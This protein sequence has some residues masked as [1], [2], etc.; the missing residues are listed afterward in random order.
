MSARDYIART[1]FCIVLLV[2][3]VVGANYSV[4]PYGI[5]GAARVDGF[6]RF[7]VDIND[8]ARLLKR[9]QPMNAEYNA[10]I[11]GNSR[12]EMGLDPSHSCLVDAG[13]NTYNLGVPG[14]SVRMQMN[15]ALNVTYQQPIQA[16]FLSLDFPDFIT[17]DPQPVASLTSLMEE[18]SGS[19][20]LLPSGLPNP[21]YRSTKALDYYKS[22]FSLDA[23]TSSV[24]TVLLQSPLAPDR[25]NR[26]FNPARDFE[27]MVMVE[28][29]RAL[30]DQKLFDLELVYRREL[31]LRYPG[32]TSSRRFEDIAE[33]LSLMRSQGVTVYV[34]INPFHQLY[35][36]MLERYDLTPLYDD[37]LKTLSDILA[38]YADAN[39]QWWDF[40]RVEPYVSEPVPAPGVRSGPLQW[41]WEPAHYRRELG[42]R[43]LESMLGPGCPGPDG[44]GVRRQ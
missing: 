20:R 5:T 44:F 14:A 2:I 26:G 42:D 22:L 1:A 33:F 32:E 4:D 10:L 6:N 29:A 25:D 3:V 21:S 39:L 11:I 28:G 35:W 18:S 17:T 34:F 36:D 8:Y 19:L 41:F 40:S 15:Y 37:W 43:M 7:K 38:T 23:L 24:K 31:F 16:V 9:Y 12:V 30:F 27:N 13:L